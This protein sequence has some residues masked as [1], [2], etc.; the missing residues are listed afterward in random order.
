MVPVA[1]DWVSNSER[2]RWF[3]VLRLH[4]PQGDQLNKL[5]RVSNQALAVF[6]QPP[7][8]ASQKQGQNQDSKQPDEAAAVEEGGT[9]NDIEGGDFTEKF[10]ISL[11][12]SLTE[13]PVEEQQRVSRVGL[14]SLKALKIPFNSVK[15]KI[16]NVVH[17]L[18]L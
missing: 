3:L 6:G 5:L 9:L 10:H 15:V 14:E 16:G 17:N 8:Y 4:K 13:P 11:A 7:L 18:E 1:L 12:W 2:T